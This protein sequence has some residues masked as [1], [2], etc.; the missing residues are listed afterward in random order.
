[1]PLAQSIQ[2]KADEARALYLAGRFDEALDIAEA[3]IE[4]P[5]PAEKL[6]GLLHKACIQSE[7]DQF[8]DSLE[9][10]KLAG[11]LIDQAP[12]KSKAAFHGQ[13][14]YCRVKLERND[15]ALVDYEAA[16]VYAQEAQDEL[17]EA[18]IRNNL[19]RVYSR[20]DRLDDAIVEND[21]A[22]H[23]FRRLNERVQLGRAYDQRAQI[24]NDGKMYADALKWSDQAIAI[25]GSHPSSVEAR[26]THGR[27]L[28][29]VGQTYLGIPDPVE[30][31]RTRREIANSINVQLDP[32]TA[33]LAL[34]RSGG[35]VQRA[36]NLLKVQ[37]Q[38]LQAS[39]KRFNL[40][41]LQKRRVRR[42]IITK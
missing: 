4:S 5:D 17:A 15:K 13:R 31:F 42:S 20:L 12:A 35:N 18:R 39:V 9:T 14:A 25:L 33:R 40:Q 37:H 34:I 24:L 6:S 10:L 27:A 38:S 16:R 41:S 21:A 7:R 22:I 23:I 3:L 29:G 11:L 28:I 30:N 2:T 32:E 26:A 8:L 36:A 1:M 19:A